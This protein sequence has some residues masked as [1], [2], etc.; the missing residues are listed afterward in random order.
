MSTT[1]SRPGRGAGVVLAGLGV[2]HFLRPELFE[3][4]LRKAYPL[5]T[6]WHVYVNGVTE[7]LM[8][9]GIFWRRT[10]PFAFAAM[11]VHAVKLRRKAVRAR[12]QPVRLETDWDTAGAEESAEVL[13]TVYSD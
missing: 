6:R 1:N 4:I 9:L 5:N 11:V 2:A 10:R 3:V 7:T 13:L 12:R 8:G